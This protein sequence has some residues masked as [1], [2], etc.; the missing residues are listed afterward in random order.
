MHA[1]ILGEV[2]EAGR[3][4]RHGTAGSNGPGAKDVPCRASRWEGVV[5]N[6]DEYM[7]LIIRFRL[8]QTNTYSE[9][10]VLSV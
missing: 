7:S 5:A 1:Y 10:G 8:L 3:D 4:R 2:V 6:C 9:T